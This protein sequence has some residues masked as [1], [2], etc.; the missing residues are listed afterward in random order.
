MENIIENI[1]VENVPQEN[2]EVENINPEILEAADA[3]IDEAADKKNKK[4]KREHISGIVGSIIAGAVNVPL[5]VPAAIGFATMLMGI[6][7][8]LYLICNSIFG[9]L[10]FA[11]IDTGILSIVA[12]VISVICAMIYLPFTFPTI[13]HFIAVI[14]NCKRKKRDRI[15]GVTGGIFNIFLSVPAAI[16]F[17]EMLLCIGVGIYFILS[18]RFNPPEGWAGLGIAIM[19]I[20]SFL[21]SGVFALAYVL[22]TLPSLSYLISAIFNRSVMFKLSAIWISI[23]Q[24]IGSVIAILVVIADVI[25]MIKG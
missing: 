23:V 13:P 5:A 9:A 1:E 11:E 10:G 4:R 19:M 2:P 20:Y 18:L 7:L 12:A 15:G 8:I 14:L 16:A 22:L 25:L 6:G 3:M 21:L 17:L 24:A